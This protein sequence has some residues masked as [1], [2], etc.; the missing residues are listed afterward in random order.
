[1]LEQRFQS[2]TFLYQH[3]PGETDIIVPPVVS[4]LKKTQTIVLKN[5][6]LGQSGNSVSHHGHAQP[7]ALK[8]RIFLSAL[9]RVCVIH[10][11]DYFHKYDPSAEQNVS[12]CWWLRNKCSYFERIERSFCGRVTH[13]RNPLFSFFSFALPPSTRSSSQ[14]ATATKDFIDFFQMKKK[15]SV[16]GI[17]IF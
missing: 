13:K 10:T 2:C 1:M 15:V 6:N 3:S 5:S 9:T 4:H 12:L 17:C 11:G 8:S 14:V 16:S 7:D